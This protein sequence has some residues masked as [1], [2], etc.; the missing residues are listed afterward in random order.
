MPAL[1]M[2]AALPLDAAWK[3]AEAAFGRRES[4]AF[5]L[6]AAALLALSAGANFQDYFLVHVTQLQPAGF[7]TALAAQVRA[8]NDRYRVYFLSGRERSLRYDTTRFLVPEYDGE[9]VGA[10]PL[11]LPLSAPPAAKGA[12]FLA[13]GAD[14]NERLEAIKRAYPRARRRLV[15]GETGDPFFFTVWVEHRDL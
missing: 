8:W 13:G 10:G 1:F 14:A 15:S 4:R 7:A 3:R 9:D 5:A 12:L 6:L 11:V 2:I